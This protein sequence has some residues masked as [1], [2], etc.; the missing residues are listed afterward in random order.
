VVAHDAGAANL[1]LPWLD[2]KPGAKVFMQ[3]PAA[4]IWHQRFP[5]R[6]LCSTLQE[7]LQ[8]AQFVLT[9]T[10]WASELEHEARVMAARQGRHC[11]AVLDHWVNYPMRF[12]RAGFTQWPDEFWVTDWDARAIAEQHFPPERVHLF[13]NLY[14]AEQ[15][16]A[17]GPVPDKGDVLYV[18]EPLSYCS[19]H[20]IPNGP[21]EAAAEFQA[22]DFF[23][24]HRE[25][26]GLDAATP[27]RLRPHPSDPEGKYDAWLRSPKGVGAQLDAH[28]DLVRAMQPAS[29]V[30]G[31]Q[32]MAMVV[33][34]CSG[35]RVASSLPPWAPRQ[36]LPHASIVSLRDLVCSKAQAR[37][38]GRGQA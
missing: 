11:A 38:D 1:M 5:S 30:V 2:A 20:P 7:T 34:L 25:V 29:W 36:Q 4:Q 14:V 21:L 33:A 9:G 18:L 27:V 23:M 8:D 32:T 16:R 37:V 19:E 31:A 3:G 28:A 35:R 22:L 26:L 6:K 24:R 13:N 12:E 17:I 15:V 10:G